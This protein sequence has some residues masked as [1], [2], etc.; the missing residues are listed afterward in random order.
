MS[1]TYKSLTTNKKVVFSTRF[2][3]GRIRVQLENTKYRS[4]PLYIIPAISTKSVFRL[5]AYGIEIFNYPKK[6]MFSINKW[7]GEVFSKIQ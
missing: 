2:K 3:D 1:T 4:E 5:S 6:D 7:P